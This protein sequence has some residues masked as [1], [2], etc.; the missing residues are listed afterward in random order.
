MNGYD[1]DG[2]PSMKELLQA[3]LNLMEKIKKIFLVSL[4][5]NRIHIIRQYQDNKQ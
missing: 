3:V 4:Q 1:N 5:V 2:F